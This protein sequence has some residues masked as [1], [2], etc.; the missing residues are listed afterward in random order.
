MLNHWLEWDKWVLTN[1]DHDRQWFNTFIPPSHESAAVNVDCILRSSGPVGL[2]L[3]YTTADIHCRDKRYE[4][5]G[6]INAAG[7]EYIEC[8]SFVIWKH[9]VKH[10]CCFL[11]VYVKC[12]FVV[13]FLL[14]VSL[15][16]FRM[17]ALLFFLIACLTIFIKHFVSSFR[18]WLFTRLRALEHY[19]IALDLYRP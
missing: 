18:R 16:G 15:L 3:R 14:L 17:S 2:I 11:Y 12:Y 19:L 8:H 6:A 4:W 9:Y 13:V 1:F 10:S 5:D 7:A